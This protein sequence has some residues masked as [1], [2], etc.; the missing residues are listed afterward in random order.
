MK[1]PARKGL[2]TAGMVFPL[3]LL[4]VYLIT[5]LFFRP[6][7]HWP[8]SVLLSAVISI[9]S[10]LFA[11]DRAHIRALHDEVNLLSVELETL[12]K[13]VRSAQ[14]AASPGRTTAQI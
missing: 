11:C 3:L 6:F 7:E 5:Y 14:P 12:R 9:L 10:G 4:G 13:N 2:E 1:S 8:V